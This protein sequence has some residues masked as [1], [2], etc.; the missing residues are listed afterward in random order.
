MAERCERAV[1]RDGVAQ[2]AGV[3]PRIVCACSGPTSLMNP[4]AY[5]LSA[6]KERGSPWEAR[7]QLRSHEISQKQSCRCCMGIKTRVV[8]GHK[9]RTI[10]V[11]VWI[12]FGCRGGAVGVRVE[13]VGRLLSPERKESVSTCVCVVWRGEGSCCRYSAECYFILPLATCQSP[14]HADT[15]ADHSLGCV[16]RLERCAWEAKHSSD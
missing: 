12:G 10:L 6:T 2:P 7:K 3:S 11:S 5:T 4:I 1:D 16:R 14:A 13:C 9:G 8:E 15:R